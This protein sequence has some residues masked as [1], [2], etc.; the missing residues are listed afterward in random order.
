[1]QQSV[2]KILLSTHDFYHIIDINQIVY[3]KSSN[4][5]TTFY[6]S[7]DE[8]I[9]TSTSIKEIEKQLLNDNF[10]RP[11]QSYLVN[12][13]FIKAVRKT[14]SCEFILKNGCC[15]PVSIRKK[16]KVLQ[17]IEKSIRFQE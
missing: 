16:M 7:N 2:K 8:K 4:S 15:I 3:C 11:H 14:S 9:T 10:I 5:Y 1:M 12:I 17:L 6:L 13:Q